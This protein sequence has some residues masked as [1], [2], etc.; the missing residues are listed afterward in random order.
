[1]AN[2]QD[3]KHI[4]DPWG[5]V[6]NSMHIY[7]Y[8][9]HTLCLQILPFFHTGS[10]SIFCHPHYCTWPLLQSRAGVIFWEGIGPLNYCISKC[11]HYSHQ[12]MSC[13]VMRLYPNHMKQ[14]DCSLVNSVCTGKPSANTIYMTAI[15][16]SSQKLT[17][18]QGKISIKATH[19]KDWWR[20]KWTRL[21]VAIYCLSTL[22]IKW[23]PARTTLDQGVLL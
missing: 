1:M 16:V 20:K 17:L 7:R 18:K 14:S 6:K 3:T 12:P 21:F 13:R 4:C 19:K 8:A 2:G 15:T 9:R 22:R 10:K 23:F 11:F 5:R